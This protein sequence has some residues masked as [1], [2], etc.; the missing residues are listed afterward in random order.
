M[1]TK[2]FLS[3]LLAA[4]MCLSLAVV[5]IATDAPDTDIRKSDG[6]FISAACS[7][8]TDLKNQIWEIGRAS[9]RERV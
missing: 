2:K 5:A 4:A 8:N 9:C 7:E 1:M 3:M 6:I